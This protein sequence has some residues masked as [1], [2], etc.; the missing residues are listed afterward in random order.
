[1]QILVQNVYIF[2]PH[3]ILPYFFLQFFFDFEAFL[4]ILFEGLRRGDVILQTVKLTEAEKKLTAERQLP[5]SKQL[6]SLYNPGFLKQRSAIQH[7][8]A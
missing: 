7:Q 6:C 4:L 2:L 8:K 3:V 5:N 1:M